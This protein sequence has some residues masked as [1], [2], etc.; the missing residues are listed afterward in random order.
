[1]EKYIDCHVHPTEA[2]LWIDASA[3][4]APAISK[5]EKIRNRFIKPLEVMA[6]DFRSQ[7][8]MGVLLAWD[9]ESG[10][11]LPKY[12][13]ERVC[14]IIKSYS[15]VFIGFA[16]VDPWKGKYA[17]NELK[18]AIKEYGLKGVKFQQGAQAFYPN[19]K[20]FCPLWKTC[21]DLN[22]PVLFHTGTTGLGA[23]LAGG[24][25]IKLDHMKPIPYIDDVAA[26]FPELKIICA[27]VSWPWADEMLAI[28]KH[29]KNVFVDL[30]GEL[31]SKIPESWK[32]MMSGQLKH[33]FL[34][35]TDYPLISPKEWIDDFKKMNYAKDVEDNILY[36]NAKA[37]LNL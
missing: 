23:G 3:N 35:G 9:A 36:K 6:N 10:T 4:L 2:R 17:I 24:G 26:D 32:A 7:N 22:V 31:P 12:P 13:N 25:G 30:S 11:G 1:M 16:S 27:H 21:S 18:I 37:V 29:K 19:E 15:D 20:I 34:F 14:E 5:S 28:V 8:T 33:K